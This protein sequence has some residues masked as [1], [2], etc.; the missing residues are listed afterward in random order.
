[1][2]DTTEASVV[3]ELARQAQEPTLV[4]GGGIYLVPGPDGDTKV[5][6]LRSK[7]EDPE[8]ATGSAIVRDAD[9]FVAY[10]NKHAGNSSEVYADTELSR[11][12]AIID[13][14][15]G[16]DSTPGWREH[17]VTLDLVHTPPWEKWLKLD[18]VPMEQVAFA[19]HIEENSADLHTPAAAVFLDIAQS[20]QGNTA[21]EWKSGER[22]ATGEV[23]FGYEE[24][25]TARAGTKG[26]L[27]IPSEFT[28]AIKPYVGGPTYK[29]GAR[30]RYKI[31]AG[32]K[33]TLTYLLDR[34]EAVLEAA[35]TD[36]IDSIRDGV[37]AADA[38]E[39]TATTRAVPAVKGRQPI[40]QLIFFGKP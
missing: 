36:I 26:D 38:V 28:L 31:G 27:E 10:L 11:V 20:L 12:I 3:A 13:A 32:G 29:V 40:P 9:S 33:L 23:K 6:D 18:G 7:G 30:F 17:K 14:H 25:T 21:V 37:P 22:L 16:L 34:P 39:A 5:V 8:R 15:G 19:N 1:M 4:P 24:T 2:T 35:F